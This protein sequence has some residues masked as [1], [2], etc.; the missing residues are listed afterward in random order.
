[1][2][3]R[4]Q[5]PK[6][7]SPVQGTEQLALMNVKDQKPIDDNASIIEDNINPDDPDDLA[8]MWEVNS[9]ESWSGVRRKIAGLSVGGL[10][11]CGAQFCALS[12]SFYDRV[13]KP[14]GVPESK[15][16]RASEAV[17]GRKLCTRARVILTTQIGN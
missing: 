7:Y 12:G 17:D 2:N 6:Q 13:I 10:L 16:L 3:R 14:M 8:A 4:N 1:M 11:D 5:L 15:I 9:T